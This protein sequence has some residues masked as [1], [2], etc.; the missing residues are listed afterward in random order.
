[1][2]EKLSRRVEFT[3]QTKTVA[4]TATAAVATAPARALERGGAAR[5][6]KAL[7]ARQLVEI[8]RTL[9]TLSDAGLPIVKALTI[10]EGQQRPGP[11]K[12][13]LAAILEDVST[14]TSLSEAMAKHP[15]TFDRLYT[16][17]VRAGEAAGEL[18]RILGQLADYLE[19]TQSVRD[20]I[21]GA[22]VYPMVVL[23]V[24]L[25]LLTL[26]F[27]VVIPK[28]QVI[29][30]SYNSELPWQT[31]AL[32]DASRFFVDRWYV[33]FGV[34]ALLFASHKALMRRAPGYRLAAHRIAL[35]LPVVGPL[36]SKILTARFAR[37][38]G[39][40]VQSGVPHLEGLEIVRGSLGNDVLAG[41]VD[42][43]R[44]SVR[45]GEG[46]A[47]PMGESGAF[48]DV[49]VNLVS[50]GESTGELDRMCLRIGDAYES[51]VSRRLDAAFKI[52]EPALLL[53]MAG[54][55]GFIVVALFLPLLKIMDAM[56][57]A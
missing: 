55:V 57:N 11:A 49:V 21:K 3:P 42:K 29:F 35:R 1:M 4:A 14:G 26:I 39:T 27:L 16:N 54:V 38:F 19:R 8:T 5:P 46:L 33:L 41:A 9:S 48:D 45:E 44:A 34:P 13:V 15:K 51:E 47:Q 40:L 31:K 50:V 10:L 12:R 30:E 43:V 20:R 6:S 52:L 32:V 36:L 25:L 18:D 17:M 23:V 53:A 37:T 24:A 56:Q 2:P 28:F 7:P 22:S